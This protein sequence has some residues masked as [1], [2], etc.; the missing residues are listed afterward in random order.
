VNK[1]HWDLCFKTK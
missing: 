1:F